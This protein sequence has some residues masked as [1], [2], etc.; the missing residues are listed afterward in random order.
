MYDAYGNEVPQQEGDGINALNL[1]WVMGFN[2]DIDQ[3][4]HNLTTDQRHEIFYSAAHTGVI[5]DYASKSQKIL[6]GHCNQITATACSDDKRWIVTADSGED[7]ML[8]VWDSLSATPVRTFLNPHPDGI[9]CLDLSADNQYL[10][11]I[12]NDIP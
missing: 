5:Y 9:K 2:K 8:I 4:V 3:G 10:V 1:Q 11:S 7:S 6:Q 12:G